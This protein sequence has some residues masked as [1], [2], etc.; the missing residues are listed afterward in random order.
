MLGH[1]MSEELV[2]PLVTSTELE[3]K[4]IVAVRM[5]AAGCSVQVTHLRRLVLE[6]FLKLNGHTAA[7]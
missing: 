1:Q 6:E 7:N 3:E 5:D 4:T 2:R